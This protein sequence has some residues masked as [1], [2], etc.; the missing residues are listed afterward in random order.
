M[1]VFVDVETQHLHNCH[2]DIQCVLE[3][4][5]NDQKTQRQLTVADFSSY[6]PAVVNYR[7]GYFNIL[8][9]FLGSIE[10]QK[11]NCPTF[12]TI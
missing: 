4:Q 11:N 8:L 1:T 6:K 2:S 5:G 7:L 3:T 12:M 9:V 10:S